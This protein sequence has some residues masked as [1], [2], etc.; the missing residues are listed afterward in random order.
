MIFLL[1]LLSLGDFYV[2][3][4]YWLI[5]SIPYSLHMVDWLFLEKFSL[6][7]SW[8][9][10]SLLDCCCRLGVCV[11]LCDLFY[12][13][14]CV[15]PLLWPSKRASYET[16]PIFFSAIK[17]DSL[18]SFHEA[19]TAYWRFTCRVQSAGLARPT[20][21][22]YFFSLSIV[23][24]RSVGSFCS[25]CSFLYLSTNASNRGD[26]VR[27]VDAGCLETSR[28]LREWSGTSTKQ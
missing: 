26:H 5:S 8:K 1:L 24:D 25:F 15:L 6:R 14:I 2:L 9:W 18:L 17:G 3:R 10:C 19:R 23:V 20:G 13:Y 12:F 7:Y 16:V 28:L 27:W 21:R 22:Y 11:L 4:L